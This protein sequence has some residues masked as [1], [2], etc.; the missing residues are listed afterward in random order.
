MSVRL[1]MITMM[2]QVQSQ[3]KAILTFKIYIFDQNLTVLVRHTVKVSSLMY[4]T[5]KNWWSDT[6]DEAYIHIPYI[7]DLW[8]AVLVGVF[9]VASLHA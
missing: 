5:Q 8:I 4:C 1:C 9:L 2:A 3:N 7:L 6:A